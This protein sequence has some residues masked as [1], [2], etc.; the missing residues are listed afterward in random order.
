MIAFSC[1]RSDAAACPRGIGPSVRPIDWSYELLSD[2]ARRTLRGLAAFVGGFTLDAVSAVCFE[3]DSSAALEHIGQLVDCSLVKFDEHQGSTRYGML[4]TVRQYAADKLAASGEAAAIR[5]RHAAFFLTLADS[6]NLSGEAEGPQDHATARREQDNIRA[7]I[8]WTATTGRIDMALSLA[9]AMENFW[10]T[11]DPF[12]GVRL[13]SRLLQQAGLAAPLQRARALRALGSSLHVIG[14]LNAARKAWEES[15]LL[16]LQSEDARAEAVLLFRLGL[17]C[18]DSG[19]WGQARHL[20]RTR[21]AGFRRTNS[22]RGEAQAIGGLRLL[23]QAT[24]HTRRARVLLSCSAQMAQTIRRTWWRCRMLLS[25]AELETAAGHL[26]EA[27][28]FSD[29][30]L[31]ERRR[32]GDRQ[33]IVHSLTRS[34]QR[35]RCGRGTRPL[36]WPVLGHGGSAGVEACRP[37]GKGMAKVTSKLQ[38]VAA[39]RSPHRTAG[40][41]ESHQRRCAVRREGRPV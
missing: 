40:S 41:G 33:I 32:I 23:E 24:G 1:S 22:R 7:A 27:K 12:E 38:V 16:F 3:G 30:A 26:D 35:D 21:L 5:G 13:L 29:E 14:E 9:V 19:E 20:L 34:T 8:E 4:E 25:L 15:L 31:A 37:L 39:A 36:G 6:A 2:S 11:S 17:I 10:V 18:V 28:R